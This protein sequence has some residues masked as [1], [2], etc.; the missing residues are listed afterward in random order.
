M[1]HTGNTFVKLGWNP[2]YLQP[3][4]PFQN[5]MPTWGVEIVCE[6]EGCNGL[7]CAIDPSQNQVNEMVGSNTDGAGG[8]AFCVVTV[9][10]GVT[11]NFVVF[12]GGMSGAGSS[13]G[14]SSS[15]VPSTSASSTYSAA[16]SSSSQPT[17]SSSPPSSTPVPSVASPSSALP[18]SSTSTS[19]SQLESSSYS[20]SS[21]WS[22][23]TASV[24]TY[25][26]TSSSSNSTSS[27]TVSSASATI[28]EYSGSASY[29]NLKLATSQP[30]SNYDAPHVF[31]QNSTATSISAV[32]SPPSN[33]SITQ[34][35]IIASPTPTAT[36]TFTGAG[37]KI[38][39]T[40]LG[41]CMSA[42]AAL[43]AGAL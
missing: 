20:S 35:T 36:S 13:S 38:H 21:S 31:L 39:A 17:S 29:A 30:V 12:E 26:S 8:A 24:E 3:G 10:Q 6:G 28:F 27:D 22:S 33:V 23:S 2:I 14:G 41:L 1:D 18:T 25:L 11:A 40:I 37:A 32:P 4:T 43:A 7:P 42:L 5:N 34:G 15:A 16:L 19:S 9:P